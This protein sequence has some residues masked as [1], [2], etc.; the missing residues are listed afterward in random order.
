MSILPPREYETEEE[1]RLAA[2]LNELGGRMLQAVDSACR[3]R[4]APGE[5]KRQR[6]LMRTN[7]EQAGNNA[8]NALAY[9]R[10]PK[11]GA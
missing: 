3:L 6:A 4:T 10:T 9:A 11:E 5:A 7:L 2:V 1:T 8:M